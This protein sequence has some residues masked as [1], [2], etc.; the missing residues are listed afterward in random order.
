M[1]G[2]GSERQ[3]LNLL[4]GLDRERFE[5]VLYLLYESGVLLEEVPEDIKRFAF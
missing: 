4:K 2:G 1:D 3:L 5:P